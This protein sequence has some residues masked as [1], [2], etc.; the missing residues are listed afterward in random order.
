MKSRFSSLV[1][2]KKNQMKKSEQSVIQ[3]NV[4]LNSASVALESSYKEL[5]SLSEPKG[6]SIKQMLSSRALLESQR[7]IIQ[8]N[9]EWVGFAKNQLDLA[10]NQLKKDTLEYEKFQYLELQE[11]KQKLQEQKLQESK[12]L[13]EIAI[14]GY[15]GKVI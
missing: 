12:E 14:M 7:E 2:L 10:K 13:D 11:I 15:K 3:A 4:N 6:G 8:N 9:K 5:Q 1:G